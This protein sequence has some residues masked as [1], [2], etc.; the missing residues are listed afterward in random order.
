MEVQDPSERRELRVEPPR[1]WLTGRRRPWR[2]LLSRTFAQINRAIDLAFAWRWTHRR[3]EAQLTVHEV[4]IR[5]QRGGAGLDGLRIAFLSDIHVGFVMDA[6]MLARVAARVAAAQPDLV[7]LGGDLINTREREILFWR[8]ALALLAAPLGLFAV[9]GN[10]DHFFGKDIGLWQSFLRTHGVESLVNRG[11]R[12]ERGGACLWLAG[13]DD[14]TDG[15]PDLEA[16]LA[17]RREDE[18]TILLSHHPDVF[19]IAQAV[20]I[21]LQLSGHT[22]GGQILLFGWAP[23]THSR[24]GWWRGH[25]V[26]N[27]AQLYV[28]RGVGVTLLPIRFA[29][30]NEVPILV[31]RSRS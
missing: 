12:I 28:S 24:F 16:A 30:P 7:C 13:I 6:A 17:G 26:R 5:L 1:N 11:V 9:P 14:L 2:R 31:L 4:E 21:D 22:H 15:E 19:Q 27:G 3:L 29:A 25:H 18:P 8:E 10:H 20:G 23:I